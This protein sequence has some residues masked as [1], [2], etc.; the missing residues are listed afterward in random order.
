MKKPLTFVQVLRSEYYYLVEA[1]EHG[2]S[3]KQL[4]EEIKRELYE[5]TGYRWM[6]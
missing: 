4:I 6:D 3:D 2:S 5:A 1:I